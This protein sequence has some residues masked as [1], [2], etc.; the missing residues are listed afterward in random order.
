MLFVHEVHHVAG[1]Q[2]HRFED[3]YREWSAQLAKGDDARLLWFMHQAH[4]AGPAYVFVTVTAVASSAALDDLDARRRA[5]GD[6][7]DWLAEVDSLRHSSSAKVLEPAPF[8]PLTD[9]DLSSVPV[10][11]EPPAD[12]TLPL[13]ME[14]TAWPHPGR[15]DDYLAKAGTLYVETLRAANERMQGKGLLE[16]V[17]AFIPRYGSGVHREIVLWQR[18]G[19]QAGLL[20]LLNREVPDAYKQPGSWMI[21]ALEVRDQWESRLLRV[22]GWSPLG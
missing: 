4:G 1:K 20:P 3:L 19:N 16:L 7:H 13:F 11:N 12:G 17:A 8:S 15:F 2:E 18:I 9:V 10:A 5:G 14:D 6:L 22:S 21:D